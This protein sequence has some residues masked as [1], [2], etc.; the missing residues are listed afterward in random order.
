MPL[1]APGAPWHPECLPHRSVASDSHAADEPGLGL[2][3]VT[4]ERPPVSRCSSAYVPG[5]RPSI[6]AHIRR[7]RAK[8]EAGSRRES[9]LRRQRVRR[10]IGN[11]TRQRLKPARLPAPRARGGLAPTTAALVGR[12]A[13]WEPRQQVSSLLT[14][15]LNDRERLSGSLYIDKEAGIAALL[16]PTHR[17]SGAHHDSFTAA[18]VPT[19]KYSCRRGW[20]LM[21]L[22]DL[23]GG[24][25]RPLA[26]CNYTASP[27]FTF[28]G[29]YIGDGPQIY[30]SVS[31]GRSDQRPLAD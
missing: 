5:S 3:H 24:A 13:L 15:F 1:D 26:C 14:P 25:Y 8:Q 23:S 21:R 19:S 27:V 22:L 16:T 4:S 31:E 18:L 11:P 10:N 28:M 12:G 9:Q 6:P 7:K 20:V 29:Q 17:N 2:A 30:A